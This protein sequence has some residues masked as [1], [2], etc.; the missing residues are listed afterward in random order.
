ML[1]I[2]LFE[3]RDSW[4]FIPA[5]GVKMNPRLPADCRTSEQE[6]ER[7]LLR[8]AGFAYLR[9]PLAYP[10]GEHYVKLSNL[11]KGYS[12]Y[13]V[14]DWPEADK[15]TWQTAHKYI[16]EHWGE[17]KS[18]DVIDCQYIR[19]EHGQPVVSEQHEP[20]NPDAKK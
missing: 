17:L 16:I 3:I 14:G 7:Y 5:M 11:T 18:G 20:V 12:T 15:H 19:G 10:P 13:N 8:R 9:P 2:K 4:T 6:R 1:E